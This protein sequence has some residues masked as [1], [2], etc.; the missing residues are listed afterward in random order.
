MK[1]YITQQGRDLLEG[2]QRSTPVSLAAGHQAAAEMARGETKA[3]KASIA[4][5][6]REVRQRG[7]VGSAQRKKYDDSGVRM[8][9]Q[10]NWRR[11]S[12]K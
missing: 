11:S 9:P 5:G 10:T 2:R 3:A 1:Y 4:R 8:A 12:D 6:R 7:R